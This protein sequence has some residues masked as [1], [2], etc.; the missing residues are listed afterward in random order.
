[1][2]IVKNGI[3]EISVKVEE[4]QIALERLYRGSVINHNA[5][6]IGDLCHVSGRCIDT[7]TLFYMSF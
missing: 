5:F 3:V 6:L 7:M 2:F 4:A 1:M